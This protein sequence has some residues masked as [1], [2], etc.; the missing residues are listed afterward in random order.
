MRAFLFHILNYSM[1]VISFLLHPL[2][3]QSGNHW[4]Y[5]HRKLFVSHAVNHNRL[6]EHQVIIT[7]YVFF[8]E[9]NYNIDYCIDVKKKNC[10][11]RNERSSISIYICLPPVLVHSTS[12]IEKREEEQLHHTSAQFE[13]EE[14]LNMHTW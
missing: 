12:F 6:D 10:T 2:T 8:T 11:S 13:K 1:I 7:A 9:T 14:K 5:I 4:L 3:S